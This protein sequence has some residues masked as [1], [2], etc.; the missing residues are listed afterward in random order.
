MGREN[1]SI[2]NP[3]VP[4]KVFLTKGVGIQIEYTQIIAINRL[5]GSIFSC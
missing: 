5:G 1:Q 2:E 4:R 3:W